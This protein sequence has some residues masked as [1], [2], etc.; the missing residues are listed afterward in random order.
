M[1]YVVVCNVLQDMIADDEVKIIFL[2]DSVLFKP[3]FDKG[4][5]IFGGYIFN[6][7][8]IAWQ[9]FKQCR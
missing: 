8:F 1:A 4:L 3:V 6:Y 2:E 7:I 5:K 9:F